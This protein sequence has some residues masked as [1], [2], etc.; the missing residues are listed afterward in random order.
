[1]LIKVTISPDVNCELYN[2][3][4]D[5]PLYKRAGVL[6]MLAEQGLRPIEASTAPKSFRGG[7]EE[8]ASEESALSEAFNGVEQSQIIAGAVF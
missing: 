5:A 1:V 8:P 2:L 4:N 6:R 7:R 3:L